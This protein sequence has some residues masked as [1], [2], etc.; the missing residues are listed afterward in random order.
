MVLRC[1]ERV[2]GMNKLLKVDGVEMFRT[3]T[4]NG[5]NFFSYKLF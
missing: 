5:R 1:L 3:C 4:R 2:R